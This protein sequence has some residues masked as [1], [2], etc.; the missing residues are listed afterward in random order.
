MEGIKVEQRDRHMVAAYAPATPADRPTFLRSL[1]N[2]KKNA[3][4]REGMEAHLQTWCEA[5]AMRENAAKREGQLLGK[6]NRQRA[7]APQGIIHEEAWVKDGES[8]RALGVPMG[9]AIRMD[10]WWT[11]KYREVKQRIAAWRSTGH[12]S[13]MA[14][15][16][17]LQAV[18]YGSLRFWLFAIVNA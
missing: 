5:T 2:K 12:M 13:I 3:A 6:L 1:T 10:I 8:I 17:L 15:T 7:R 18:L 11:A 14:R 9:N 4:K 16:L